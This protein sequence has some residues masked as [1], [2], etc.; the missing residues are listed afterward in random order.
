MAGP[1]FD[2]LQHERD[3]R[4]AARVD[5]AVTRLMKVIDGVL[6]EAPEQQRLML[7]LT[8]AAASCSSCA[9]LICDMQ[10]RERGPDGPTDAQLEEVFALLLSANN[11]PVAAPGRVN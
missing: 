10:G 1:R 4:K 7:A 9:A 11:T 3:Q 2:Q 5:R 8:M 6:R